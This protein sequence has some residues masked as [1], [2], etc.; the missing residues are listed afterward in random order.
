MPIKKAR[1]RKPVVNAAYIRKLLKEYTQMRGH[2]TF[3]DW[4][5]LR[6]RAILA[7]AVTEK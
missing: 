2:P 1:A 6:D 3:Q 5:L 4:L 7:L